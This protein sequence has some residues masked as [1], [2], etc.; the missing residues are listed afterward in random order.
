LSGYG[1]FCPVSKAMEL[2]DER[3]TMLV[4]RELLLGSRHF[5]ELRRG[6][7][8]MSPALLS[9]RLRTLAKAG[10]VERIDDGPRVT[11]A[12]TEA[13]RELEPIVNALGRWGVRWIPE[14][15]DRDLDPKLLLWDMHRN[16]DL[17][18]VPADRTVLR[19][20]FSDLAGPERQWWMVITRDGV[21]LC[22]FDPGH[23][24]RASVETELRTLTRIWRGDLGWPEALAS[25]LVELDGAVWARRGVPRWL[26]QS[27]LADTPRP[28]AAGAGR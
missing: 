16:V 22:D 20:S 13:G 3:W 1:Q 25:G 26:G 15:G 11:Y 21:D 24:E 9:K 18:A 28:V 8:R 19:F 2:L 12:L 4:V 14:L 17:A 23:P 7:P 10:V 27:P 6:V 5:N